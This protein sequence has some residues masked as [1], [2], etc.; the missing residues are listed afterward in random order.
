LLLDAAA[1]GRLRVQGT[2]FVNSDGSTFQ[3]RGITA[4]RLADYIADGDAARAR[5]FLRWARDRRLTVVRVFAMLQ[6]FFDLPAARGRAALPT[7]LSLAA[8]YGLHVEVVGLTGTA[9]ATAVDP[10]QQVEALG[11]IVA[12]H[13]NALLEVANEPYHPTQS[14]DV[15]RPQYLQQLVAPVP[16]TVAVSL[17]SIE[18]DPAF[19]AGAYVT[20]HVPRRAS[21]DGWG[22]VLAIAEGAGFPRQFNKPVISDEPIGAGPKL[23]PGRRD[24]EPDRFRAAALLTR[25]AGLG[26]TFHYEGGLHARIPE[27]RELACFNAWNEAWTLLPGSIEQRGV[28]R[29]AGDDGAAVRGF[30][31]GTAL[32]VFERQDADRAWVLV[33]RPAA[34]VKVQ[35]AAG[36]TPQTTA[37]AGGVQVVVAGRR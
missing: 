8:T 15:H 37:K 23:Q 27:G 14:A 16:R 17:G 4:F 30:D 12:R 21:E 9:D 25:L 29:K 5:V 13:D 7:L 18:A 20:W 3:W 26:A 36:W 2:R 31:R 19:A 34:D 6:G 33:V 10:R 11:G 24:D 1:P 22:H 28:F 32:A 35:W